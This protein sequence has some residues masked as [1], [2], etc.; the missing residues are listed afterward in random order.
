MSH[1]LP[2]QEH[3][4]LPSAPSLALVKPT[5]TR[6]R[7]RLHTMEPEDGFH[8]GPAIVKSANAPQH[9][10]A[11]WR[12]QLLH[13]ELSRPAKNTVATT[14]KSAL[15]LLVEDSADATLHF[16][17]R[18]TPPQALATRL[19]GAIAQFQQRATKPTTL[20]LQPDEQMAADSTWWDTARA[21]LDAAEPSLPNL[22][23]S[24]QLSH[25]PATIPSYPGLRQLELGPV[26]QE[27]SIRLPPPTDLPHLK[28]LTIG[29]VLVQGHETLFSSVGPY[30]TQLQTLSLADN[31]P[32]WFDALQ[33]AGRSQT[34]TRLDVPD[35]YLNA[36]LAGWLHDNAPALD[37]L[38]V[39]GLRDDDYE[40]VPAVC[41]WRT[42]R[43]ESLQLRAYTL[44][45]LPVPAEGKLTIEIIGH[46]AATL[47][48]ITD[49]E[50]CH[51]T[52]LSMYVSPPPLRQD[53]VLRLLHT[54]TTTTKEG[55]LLLCH[56]R[57]HV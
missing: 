10:P 13:K 11:P 33:G 44:G 52:Y 23:V 16:H 50:V 27:Y 55:T 5:S 39:F 1:T 17:V 51:R 6:P 29:P 34:L 37:V 14:C 41:S 43:I 12:Q 42:L 32:A 46:E 47:D 48:F 35:L 40:L 2:V 21:V 19:H 54:H 31:G 15:Q 45:W 26:W 25:I 28:H 24:M 56:V 38:T 18:P 7:Q 53:T 9:V 3:K 36:Y 49:L 30:F 22:T 4:S 8:L 57:G 20:L